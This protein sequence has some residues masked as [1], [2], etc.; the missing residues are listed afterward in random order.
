MKG[1][2][3][4][5]PPDLYKKLQRQAQTM[6]QSV[7]HLVEDALQRSLPPPV[8]TTLPESLQNEFKAMEALSD[9]AL[10]PIGQSMM[11]LD[12]VAMYDALLERN[13][14]GTLTP[15]GRNWL[16]DLRYEADALMLR[17][18]SGLLDFAEPRL[19]LVNYN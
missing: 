7:D 6:R 16:T 3:V 9:D 10:W 11:N 8:E 5:L 12:K 18:A 1:Y 14:A 19:Y 13:R 2:T 4:T 17:K 15:E